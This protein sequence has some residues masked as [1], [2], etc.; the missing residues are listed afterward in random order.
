MD[1]R[2][3]R[4]PSVISAL[5]GALVVCTCPF[6]DDHNEKKNALKLHRVS[7]SLVMMLQ[8]YGKLHSRAAAQTRETSKVLAYESVRPSYRAML[9]NTSRPLT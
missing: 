5:L 6:V 3:I 7:I 2:Y 1:V 4:E 9:S 8:K